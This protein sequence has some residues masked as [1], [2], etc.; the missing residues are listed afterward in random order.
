V[1]TASTTA[2]QPA[3]PVTRV[4]DQPGV[5][6]AT[7]ETQLHARIPGYVALLHVDIGARV[8]MGDVLAE[9][10]APELVQEVAAKKALVLRAEAEANQARKALASS[11][12]E[13]EAKSA[14]IA[15]TEAGITRTEASRQ[16][17][18]IESERMTRL[19][20]QGILDPQTRDE[21][22]N[23]AAAAQASHAEALARV[24][25]ARALA[26]KAGTDIEKADADVL[27]AEAQVAVAKAEAGRVEAMLAFGKITAPYDGV[28]T[29]R[30]VNTGD[31]VQPTVGKPDGLFTVAKLDPVRIVI[32]VPEADAALVTDGSPVKLTIPALKGQPILARV[33]RSSWALDP[34]S[35]TLRV[36]IDQPNADHRLRPG[37]FVQSQITVT[38]EP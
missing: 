27:A 18:A 33:T 5:I 25:S 38:V 36:E 14:V 22:I 10:S 35:R 30:R 26:S 2:L 11:R 7:E 13:A 17:W 19:V 34:G 23:Q 32:Q 31:F 29:R 3:R 6:Q 15:E 16:R 4:V 9:L 24:T 8:K 1:S 28:V 12:A 21:T 37:M 20:Q